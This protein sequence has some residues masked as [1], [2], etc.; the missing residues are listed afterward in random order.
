MAL[1]TEPKTEISDS[2]PRRN[3]LDGFFAFFRTEFNFFKTAL[4][5]GQFVALLL[6]SVLSIGLA[7]QTPVNWRVPLGLLNPSDHL[8]I[9][10]FNPPEINPEFSFRW[11]TG[12]SYFRFPGAGRLPGAKLEVAMQIGGRPPERGFPKVEIWQGT[13]LIGTAEVRP[14]VPRYTFDYRAEG[15]RFNGDLIFRLRVPDAFRSA[16]HN[17]PLGVVV[18]E[19]TLN[20]G[21]AD[22]RPVIPSVPHLALL[23]VTIIGLY[24][25]LFRAGWTLNRAAIFGAIGGVGAAFGIAFYRFH[26]T[27]AVEVLCLTML[28]T[29]PL[30]VLGLRTTAAWL[31]RRGKT[32]EITHASW[33]GLFFV[34][35][36][37]LK[38]AGMNHPTFRTIDH[39]FRVHQ[40][41][42]FWE[43]PAN[44]W[45]QYYN[46]SA[47]ASVTGAETGSAVLGQWGVQVSMPYS[48]LFYIFAAPLHLLWP[49][50]NDP[51]LLIAVNALAGWLELSQLFLLYIIVRLMFAT[52]W[53]GRAGVI[54]AGLA[55]F[56]PLSFLL[57]SD[58]GYNGIFAN[59]LTLL[60]IAL[61]LTATSYKLRANQD[62]P[63]ILEKSHQS[64]IGNFSSFILHPSSFCAVLALAAALLAHTS[65]LLLLGAF[66]FVYTA[67]LLG[68]K[69]TRQ[70]GKHVAL[71]GAGGLGLALLLYYGWYIP[72]LVGRT[73]PTLLGRLGTEGIGQ[74]AEKLGRPLLGGFFPQLWEHFRFFPFGLTLLALIY[75]LLKQRKNQSS[76]INHQSSILLA[77]IIVL[78]IFSIV[79]LRVNLLQKHMLFAAPLLCIGAGVALAV[80]YEWARA[81][82]ERWMLWAIGGVIAALLLYNAAT[83]TIIWY[84]R[85]Y[86]V[87]YQPGSG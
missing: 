14:D 70:S 36:F 68:Q 87:I 72:A 33:L 38:V 2:A 7:Y 77:W 55:A 35:G 78:G 54:A 27:P 63:A 71:I 84:G 69:V 57:F 80:G 85:V 81:R 52:V 75:L 49:A 20:G 79:D 67:I 12:E 60:F 24:L 23:T 83:G 86:Y 46:V 30:L 19:V 59:W 62:T 42:R 44:F 18:T 53:A 58:G 15:E 50:H 82:R 73:L 28:L 4:G 43:Q 56:Y 5:A 37:V 34:M 29:Y 25:A 13:R 40:I 10:S 41:N 6:F 64:S 22:S 26:L 32:L 17:L 21:Q 31:A 51:N 48:P 47:G 11:S 39:W 8:Y 65:T 45:Q 9:Q 3:F 61:L 76:I 16:G 1:A 74:S 66:V